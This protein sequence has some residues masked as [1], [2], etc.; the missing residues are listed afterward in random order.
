MGLLGFTVDTNED[1]LYTLP[2]L[3]DG[4]YTVRVSALSHLDQSQLKTVTVSG[5]SSSLDFRLGEDNGDSGGGLG[6]FGASAGNM[7]FSGGLGP[8][9]GDVVLLTLFLGA[10][11]FHRRKRRTPGGS[12][13]R[14][15]SRQEPER[16]RMARLFP[17]V[18]CGRLSLD[19]IAARS[20]Q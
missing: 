19:P 20:F 5:G 12:R 15:A 14:S 17:A 10:M 6:C 16:G 18:Y 11:L 9:M 2:N 1:G 13:G 7:E 8:A 4:D 3:E